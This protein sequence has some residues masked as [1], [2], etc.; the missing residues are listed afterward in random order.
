MYF[1]GWTDEIKTG[2]LI[3]YK[4]EVSSTGPEVTLSMTVASDFSWTVSYRGQH[5]SQENCSILRS[6]PLEVNTGK[7]LKLE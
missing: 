2:M 4:L 3:I 6:A 7:A 1:V 5:V